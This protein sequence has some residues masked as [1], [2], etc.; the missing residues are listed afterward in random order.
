MKVPEYSITGD[1][2]SFINCGLQYRYY[3]RGKLIPSRQ[4][5]R[6]FGE[7]IHG[8][9]EEA[10]LWWKTSK[11][12]RNFPW[13]WREHIRPI[14]L[15]VSQRLK[16]KGLTPPFRI[17]CPYE[18]HNNMQGGCPDTSHPHKL[19]ASKRAELA[20][21]VWGQHLFPL[22]TDAEVRLRANKG[23]E[24]LKNL[25]G[26]DYYQIT[27]V[28]DVISSIKID[29][30]QQEDN[31]IVKFLR[32]NEEVNRVIREL[33]SSGEED[34][35]VLVDYKGMRRPPLQSK[36]WEAHEWQILTYA[37]L[38]EKQIGKRKVTAGILIY[39]NELAPSKED[40]EQLYDE[41]S[42]ESTDVA[43]TGEDMQA[44]LNWR[45]RGRLPILSEEYRKKRSIRIIP[46]HYDAIE[47]ALKEFD[48]VVLEIEKC[49]KE[50]AKK[51]NIKE[52][53]PHN[54]E[55]RNCDICD[56]N[57]HCYPDKYSIKVP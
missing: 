40:M 32:E 26:V 34:Y 45:K 41:V 53:W 39:I 31:E 23:M 8:V 16:S 49:I 5:Q 48:A 1:I 19:I 54:F 55:K 52:A 22:I 2:L 6:W 29:E 14:E 51:V 25:R 36:T 27:G 50:E 35:E 28:A 17:F 18:G 15:T 33:K 43:P 7:F 56:F 30:A 46:I 13:G 20:I 21:N 57:I 47:K 10:Y 12:P 9:M 3:N 44:L 24:K 42:S 11:A 37:W 4:I 38:R